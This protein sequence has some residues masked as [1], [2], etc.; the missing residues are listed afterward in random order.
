MARYA[1]ANLNRGELD[2]RR[3]LPANAYETLW[4]P[5]AKAEGSGPFAQ[6]GCGWYVGTFEGLRIVSHTGKDLGFMSDL[7]LLP[8]QHIAVIWMMNAGW[9]DRSL[10]I[11]DA[12]LNIALGRPMQKVEIR[13]D[14][15]AVLAGD[16]A[17]GKSI[18]WIREKYFSLRKTKQ[19]KFNFEEQRLD[20]LGDYLMNRQKL[21]DAIEIY[22][23]NVE[24]YPTS[25]HALEKLGDA[26][27]KTQDKVAATASYEASLK[28][29]PSNAKVQA[30]LEQLKRSVP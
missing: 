1:I 8:D 2:G 10:S 14:L 6:Y 22:R 4:K 11:S 13:R 23:L 19:D 5:A 28:L 9:A 21:H 16:L 26:Q 24:A 20:V 7:A 17:R 29:Q 27:A 12:A 18:E 30:K 15:P 3:I 25:A